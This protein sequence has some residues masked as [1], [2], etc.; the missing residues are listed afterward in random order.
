MYP[1]GSFL[2]G[3][4]HW[5]ALPTRA[6]NKSTTNDLGF[7]KAVLQK[8]APEDAVDTWRI[9]ACE[10]SNEGMLAYGLANYKNEFIA[11]IASV[12][13]AQLNFN[14]PTSPD[15]CTARSRYVWCGNS[16]WWEQFL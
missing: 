1:Q 13:G 12:S 2:N 8:I 6:N 9:Y 10:Y 16:L 15:G 11:A 3:T 5:N 7:V 14:A 4:S